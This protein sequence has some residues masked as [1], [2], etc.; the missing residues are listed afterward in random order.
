M[1]ESLGL[2]LGANKDENHEAKL[3]QRINDWLLHQSGAAWDNPAPIRYLLE[4][5]AIREVTTAYISQTLLRSPRAKAFLG[6]RNLLRFRRFES[7]HAPWGWK[8]PRNTF[9]LPLWLDIFPDARVI[10]VH[11]DGTDVALSLLHRGRQESRLQRHYRQTRVL[12]WVRPKRGGFVHSLRCDSSDS[13]LSLWKE[14]VDQASRHVTMLKG[15]ALEISFEDLLGRPH[16]SLAML[17]AF[18]ELRADTRQIE[19]AV[20]HINPQILARYPARTALGVTGCG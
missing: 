17:A 11:R 19:R 14:Y 7:L 12:H 16:E 5:A 3:F 9:T 1:L 10:H 8:D 13:A 2:F 20:R 4:N 6:W 15:R 18:C